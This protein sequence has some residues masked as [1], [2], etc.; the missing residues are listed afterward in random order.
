MDIK[1]IIDTAGTI[2][3]EIEAGQGGN[4]M[5][6]PHLATAPGQLGYDRLVDAMN[7]LPRPLMAFATLGLF[8]AAALDPAGFERLMQTVSTMPQPLWWLVG[9]AMTFFFGA[10]EA[11]YMRQTGPQKP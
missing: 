7:R 4:A 1:T 5:P 10:R 9:A 6:K 2:A 3:Q 11:H 8:I